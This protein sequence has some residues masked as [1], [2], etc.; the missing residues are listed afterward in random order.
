MIFFAGTPPYTLESG[1][2]FVT[3]EFAPNTQNFPMVTPLLTCTLVPN[4]T[5]S[6]I[7]IGEQSK[8][9]VEAGDLKSNL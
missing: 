2:F 3:T 9:L 1:I 8:L 5:P 4:Q 6:F 7:S